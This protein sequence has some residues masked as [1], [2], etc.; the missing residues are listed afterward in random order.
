VTALRSQDAF[1]QI[2][3]RIREAENPFDSD[4]VRKARDVITDVPDIHEKAYRNL[5]SELQRVRRSRVSRGVL[6]TGVAG[7]GKSH[8]ISRLYRGRPGDVLFFQIEA[9][10]GGK[11]WLKQILQC[12]VNDLEQPV[13]P[14]N[15]KIQLGVLI[16]HLIGG[17]KAE[18]GIASGAKLN[19]D[20]LNKALEARCRQI[21]R[22]IP[23]PLVR[24]VLHVLAELYRWQAPFSSKDP[25]RGKKTRLAIQWLKGAMIDDEELSLIGVRSNF[26][27]DAESGY[28]SHLTVLR[29]F[30]MLTVGQAPIILA[31]DQLDTM[32]EAT[33]NSLGNQLLEL[34]GSSAAAPNYLVVTAGVVEQ[35]DIF[36]KDRIVT[37]AVADVIFKTRIDLMALGME[38]C[39]KIVEKRLD[40]LLTPGQRA[41][42]PAAADGL[43]PF[44]DEFLAQRLTGPIKPS[45][46]GAIKVA[47]SAFDEIQERATPE[48]VSTWPAV[49][50]LVDFQSPQS[51]PGA[52]IVSEFLLQEFGKNVSELSAAEAL[53]PIDQDY[54]SDAIRVLLASCERKSPFIL[55]DV[56]KAFLPAPAESMFGVTKV[57]NPSLT[58]WVVVENR[59]HWKTVGAALKKMNEFLKRENRTQALLF[60]RDSAAKKMTNWAKCNEQIAG[61]MKTGRFKSVTVEKDDILALRSLDKMRRDVPDFVIP[62]SRNHSQYKVTEEDY[63]DFL[64]NSGRFFDL[65][66]FREADLFLENQVPGP[67]PSEA[68]VFVLARIEAKKIYAYDQMVVDWAHHHGRSTVEEDDR[69]TIESTVTGLVAKKKI[70]DTGKGEHRI[71]KKV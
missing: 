11:G 61:L 40:G 57:S 50:P 66:L 63:S 70:E 47:R 39:R 34:I 64:V 41:K 22:T 55:L 16:R 49:S 28:V 32:E 25:E 42:L 35:M 68:G 43:F 65:S 60:L 33:I 23:D 3:G 56:A 46:R 24:D 45:P 59:G 54:L 36:L 8:L 69:R 6:I 29:V 19:F 53:G 58:V 10:P 20:H 44:T 9:L 26:G 21:E 37:N 13:G 48:W 71:L 38:D 12:I 30:G 62:A 27:D 5:E 15:Q 31:F 18:L 2:A 14:E 4:K 7:S 51:P 17:V 1:S 52:E 67:P